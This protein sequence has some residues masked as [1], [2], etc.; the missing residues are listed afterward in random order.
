MS[1]PSG[2]VAVTGVSRRQAPLAA[3]SRALAISEWPSAKET[4]SDAGSHLLVCG[5]QNATL[6]RRDLGNAIAIRVE[7]DS[8]E[9]RMNEGAV[10]GT[11]GTNDVT[12]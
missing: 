7:G 5:T 1:T 3:A 6:K 10:S 8:G 4:T 11:G 9:D 2:A 12:R